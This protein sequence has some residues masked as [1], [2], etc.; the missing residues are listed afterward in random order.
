MPQLYI[1][2]S[3]SIDKYYVG[4]T[5]DLEDRLKRHNSDKDKFTS[6]GQPWQLVYVEEYHT[7]AEAM[8]R[9]REIK[10]KKSRNYIEAL[11]A[12]RIEHPDSGRGG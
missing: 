10:K 4:A 8:R 3:P 11:V 12:K 9:E 7:K 6:K 5:N 2:Y 1:L